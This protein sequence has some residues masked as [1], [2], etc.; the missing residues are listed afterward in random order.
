MN[1]ETR[2]ERLTQMN[3]NL[4]EYVLEIIPKY[5]KERNIYNSLHSPQEAFMLLIK[6][7]TAE[8]LENLCYELSQYYDKDICYSLTQ[9]KNSVFSRNAKNLRTTIYNSAINC[10]KKGLCMGNQESGNFNTTCWINH[11][12]YVSQL[13]GEFAKKMGLDI[14]AAKTLGLV[15][16]IG[17]KETHRQEHITKGFEILINEGWLQEAPITLTHSYID[18]KIYSESDKSCEYLKK[19]LEQYRY[20]N[21][22][23]IIS[24][25]DLM[26]APQG[27][28]S[29]FDRLKEIENRGNTDHNINKS[30]K[31]HVT[32][33]LYELLKR[34]NLIEEY[35][36][37]NT[38][39]SM[40][41]LNKIFKSVSNRF[42]E[43]YKNEVS[44][45]RQ[46]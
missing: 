12:L 5:S 9:G 16:D 46:R 28:V 6:G 33:K 20:T 4:K 41:R 11:C 25:A 31:V 22:D 40:E 42:F 44:E 27:I 13:A 7:L 2:K 21:Y 35:T 10:F 14:N 29:P 45:K 18:G 38:E 30:F 19:F 32:N 15:H 36:E 3:P 1:F 34:F 8:Q 37:V 24:I 23:T 17:R 43:Y 39:L 26:A